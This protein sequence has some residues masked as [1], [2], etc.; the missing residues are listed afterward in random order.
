MGDV[1]DSA[2]GLIIM[3]M[4]RRGKRELDLAR[5]QLIILLDC[6]DRNDTKLEFLELHARALLTHIQN[7][8]HAFID[9]DDFNEPV[10]SGA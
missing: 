7:A 9:G 8:G 4:D 6:L 1:V 3:T 10:A 2:T 5:E